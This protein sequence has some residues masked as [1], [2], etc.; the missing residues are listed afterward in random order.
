MKKEIAECGTNVKIHH[1]QFALVKSSLVVVVECSQ[2][3]N[4]VNHNLKA[5]RYKTR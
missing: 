2:L 3:M 4:Q 5:P 1:R